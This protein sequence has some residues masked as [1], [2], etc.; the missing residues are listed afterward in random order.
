MSYERRMPMPR[1]PKMPARL[2]SD[3]AVAVTRVDDHHLTASVTTNGTTETVIMSEFNAWRVFGMLSVMLGI[4]LPVALG[5]AI[6][7]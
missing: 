6:K 5:K 2:P 7:L 1:I 3:G 4:P